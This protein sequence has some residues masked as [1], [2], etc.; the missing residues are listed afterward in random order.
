[1]THMKLFSRLGK[2]QKHIV[3]QMVENDYYILKTRDTRDRTTTITLMG[4]WGNLDRDLS[5]NE[6]KALWERGLLLT[7]DVS[8]CLELIQ[9]KFFL[10][11]R[12]AEDALNVCVN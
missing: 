5:E 3:I 10:N 11:E 12:F 9:R 7:A 6:L 1:M 8:K 4:E 2:R